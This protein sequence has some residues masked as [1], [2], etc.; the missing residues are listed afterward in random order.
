M[1]KPSH[2]LIFA[3]L[4]L[5]STPAFAEDEPDTRCLPLDKQIERMAHDFHESP[6]AV[7]IS[8]KSLLMIFAS[9]NGE[10]WTVVKV[11]PDKTACM[12]DGGL[13]LQMLKVEQGQG[14]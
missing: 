9:P 14:T 13:D 2:A 6:I 11:G 5:L 8:E 10:T 4:T 1:F 12:V 7:G 3:A